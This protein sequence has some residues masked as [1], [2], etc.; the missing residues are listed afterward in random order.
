MQASRSL[1]HSL[2]GDVGRRPHCRWAPAGRIPGAVRRPGG[3]VSRWRSAGTIGPHGSIRPTIATDRLVG[4][5]R[6]AATGPG[7]QTGE[8]TW[9][10]ISGAGSW[11]TMSRRPVPRA[12]PRPRWSSWA[13]ACPA[14]PWPS[15]SSGRGSGTSPSSNG[16]RAWVEPGG[17]HL[18]GQRLRCPFPPVLVL[19]RTQVGLVPTVRRTAGDPH[20]RRAVRTGVPARAPSPV[21]DHGAAGRPRRH[22]RPVAVGAQHG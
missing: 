12:D 3:G 5:G 9:P 14:W 18:P 17:Q 22:H 7:E 19:V 16:P 1:A 2:P 6:R 10:W 21:A 4:S 11:N 15:S 8:W 13:E 20:L